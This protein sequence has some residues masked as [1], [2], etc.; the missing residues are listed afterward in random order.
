MIAPRVSVVV[1]CYNGGQFLDGLLASL[2]AQ[3]FRDFEIVIVDDGSNQTDTCTKLASLN[4]AVRLIRQDNAGLP[5]ARNTGFRESR[6]E[7]VL[8]LDCDDTLEPS[9]LK[10]MVETLSQSPQDVGFAFCHIRLVGQRQGVLPRYLNSFDQLFL[11]SLPYCML[12]RRAAWERAGGYDEA[13][14]DG[15]EDWEFNIRLVHSGFRGLEVPKPLFI[16]RVSM[17]GMLMSRSARMHGDLW[18]RIRNK[19]AVLYRAHA[20]MRSWREMR[21]SNARI[22]IGIAIGMLMLARTLP[23]VWFS[24]LFYGLLSMRY[25]WHMMRRSI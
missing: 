3:T 9:F 10:E 13:M 20:I 22:S 5:A 2:A 24:R 21:Y 23:G 4:S 14:R 12:I 25:R 11:N 19:H 1:P 7:F 18:R 17:D 16:Y 6:G 8:P 15:Y